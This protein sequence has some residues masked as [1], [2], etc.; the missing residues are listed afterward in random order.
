MSET[1]AAPSAQPAP[2][3]LTRPA[4]LASVAATLPEGAVTNA[5][6]AARLGVTEDWIVERTGVRERRVAT[7]EQTLV[8][9]ATE[10]ARKAAAD[11][12][13][14]PG[15]IDL[16][17]AATMSH[18][19]LTPNLA[20]LVAAA[21]GA[22]RAGAF[23]V[24]GACSGFMGALAMAAG[25]VESGRADAVIV[26]GADQMTRLIDPADRSTAALFGDGAGAVAV[27]PGRDGALGIGPVALGQDGSRGD[28]VHADRASGILRMEGQDTFREAVRRLTEV[29]VSAVAAAELEL[30]DI[31]AFVYHQ[32]NVRILRSVGNR[33]KLPP[34]RVVECISRYGNTSAASIPIA[35]ADATESGLLTP[36]G[37]ALLGAF[38]GG[39]TWGAS[40]I[41]WGV[42]NAA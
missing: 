20:P 22:D 10:A 9:L 37:R 23:D 42:A 17:L 26:L 31:D 21:I 24:G 40:V 5:P 4:A 11:A 12:G 13:I 36:G 25:Q 3:A 2:V 27:V 16:V 14:A 35:L 18:D 8:E 38:G 6:I 29:T 15:E 33:L 41:E 19:R 28:L 7:G 34:E 1:L 39:L 30:G 32:A